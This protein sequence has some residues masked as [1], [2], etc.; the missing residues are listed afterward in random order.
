MNTT[1]KHTLT[2]SQFLS[3]T[4]K[5]NTLL[6]D[7]RRVRETPPE[8]DENTSQL[9]ATRVL[10]KCGAIREGPSFRDPRGEW[11][12]G[13]E[14]L[15]AAVTCGDKQTTKSIIGWCLLYQR[16]VGKGDSCGISEIVDLVLETLSERDL[17]EARFA[18]LKS[19]W[20]KNIIKKQ[21]TK[22]KVEVCEISPEKPGPFY[23][24]R[25][26]DDV[27]TFLRICDKENDITAI[28]WDNCPVHFYEDAFSNLEEFVV[29][30]RGV[31]QVQNFVSI[32]GTTEWHPFYIKVVNPLI[33]LPPGSEAGSVFQRVLRGCVRVA[34]LKQLGCTDEIDYASAFGCLLGKNTQ[35]DSEALGLLKFNHHYQAS[36][37]RAVLMEPKKTDTSGIVGLFLP[38]SPLL[39][40]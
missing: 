21:H 25:V 22:K 6:R 27:I 7:L 28:A 34:K 14:E 3:Q 8:P 31:T 39:S 32:A 4:H 18:L 1:T 11:D 20:A 36:L 17:R 24:H 16:E 9:V 19:P 13:I 33:S 5:M 38:V 37:G 12:P 40:S 29:S 10:E 26:F 2:D 15:H 23:F 30:Q 35:L